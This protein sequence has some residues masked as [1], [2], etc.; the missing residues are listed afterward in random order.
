MRQSHQQCLQFRSSTRKCKGKLSLYVGW[1]QYEY[2]KTNIT[3]KDL[4]KAGSKVLKRLIN[5][6][7]FWDDVYT[8]TYLGH[9]CNNKECLYH[10]QKEDKKNFKTRLIF[11]LLVT[12]R[13]SKASFS[14]K[15]GL[16]SIR[17]IQ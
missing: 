2:I 8:Y 7:T 1:P 6:T 15:S 4:I 12:H 17:N 10:P 9:T 3:T 14:Y 13:S 16:P 11:Q 5:N